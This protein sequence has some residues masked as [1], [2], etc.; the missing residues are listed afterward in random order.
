M[1]TNT[2][3]VQVATELEFVFVSSKTIFLAEI[4]VFLKGNVAAKIGFQSYA[5]LY[6]S[7]G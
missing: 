3:I 6:P 4:K 1:E 2:E 7:F 5:N